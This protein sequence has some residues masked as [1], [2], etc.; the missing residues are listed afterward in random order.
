MDHTEQVAAS[1]YLMVV[2]R[3]D[4]ER[5]QLL[6]KLF[7]GQRVEVVR[8]RRVGDRRATG[9]AAAAGNRRRGERRAPLP[10]SWVN[11]GFFVASRHNS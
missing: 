11:L 4:E 1:S 9:A 2:Q 7:Q 5:Y 8:D 6:R 3:D 10:D